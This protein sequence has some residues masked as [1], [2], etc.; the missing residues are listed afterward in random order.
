MFILSLKVSQCLNVKRKPEV[1]TYN[2]FILIVNQLL[3]YVLKRV[4]IGTET[5][6]AQ[7]FL[8]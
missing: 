2:A 7:D 3:L 4:S 1:A 8:P 6:M 5:K